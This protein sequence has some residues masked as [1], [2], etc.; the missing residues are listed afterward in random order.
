MGQSQAGSIRLMVEAWGLTQA[1]RRSPRQGQLLTPR[2]VGRKQRH[3]L[4]HLPFP[5][6]TSRHTRTHKRARARAHSHPCSSLPAQ[7]CSGCLVW[8][9]THE[10]L[11]TLAILGSLRRNTRAGTVMT[12]RPSPSND[13]SIRAANPQLPGRDDSGSAMAG[14]GENPGRTHTLRTLRLLLR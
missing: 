10:L 9:C 7:S 4:V 1:G 5:P 6:G 11:V 2:G 13:S 12:G 3:R 14:T 8:V